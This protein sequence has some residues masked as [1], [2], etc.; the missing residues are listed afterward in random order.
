[1]SKATFDLI[2]S[3]YPLLEQII[4]GSGSHQPNRGEDFPP[5][6][7]PAFGGKAQIA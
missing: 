3:S 6:R 4:F 2:A 5:V 7:R 1:M